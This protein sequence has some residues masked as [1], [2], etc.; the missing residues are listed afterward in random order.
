MHPRFLFRSTAQLLLCLC[1][2]LFACCF[3]GSQNYNLNC[4]VKKKKGKKEFKLNSAGSTNHKLLAQQRG[5]GMGSL[6]AGR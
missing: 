5:I 4:G 2:L 6:V 1:V 3:A